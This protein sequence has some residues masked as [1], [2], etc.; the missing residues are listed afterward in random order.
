MPVVWTLRDL[1][2]QRGITRASHVSK[3]VYER[4]GYRLST[5]AVCDLLNGEP[6]MIRLETAQALCDSFYFRISDFFEMMPA[7]ARKPQQKRPPR[8]EAISPQESEASAP[9]SDSVDIPDSALGAAKVDFASFF[10][11]AGE[12]CSPQPI[13]D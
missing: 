6:K 12:L 1:L 10:A 9:Q 8:L 4:T 3:I 13:R 7:A 11:A 2:K 5:Q